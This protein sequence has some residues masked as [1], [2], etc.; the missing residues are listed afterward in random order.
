M[1]SKRH[2]V[3]YLPMVVHV[4]LM[5]LQGTSGLPGTPGTPGV[6]GK[7]VNKYFFLYKIINDINS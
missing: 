3:F 5:F 2:A 7:K 4:V 6:R 1:I